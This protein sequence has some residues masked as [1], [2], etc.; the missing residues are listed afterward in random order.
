MLAVHKDM[1]IDIEEF[2]AVLDDALQILEINAVGQREQEKVLYIFFTV[3][4]L[5]LSMSETMPSNHW[6]RLSLSQV[7]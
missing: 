7:M 1:D 4:N 6:H 2:V 5:K 3:C